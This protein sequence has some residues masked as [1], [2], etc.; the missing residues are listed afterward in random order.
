MDALPA[1]FELAKH[2]GHCPIK[3]ADIP[4]ARV[5][6]HRLPEMVLSPPKQTGFVRPRRGSNGGY[7]LVCPSEATSIAG[8]TEFVGGPVG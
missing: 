5:I 1:A 8:V 6:P 4:K 7:V 2:K 3:I